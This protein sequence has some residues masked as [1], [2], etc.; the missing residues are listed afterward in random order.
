MEYAAEKEAFRKQTE[1]M[2]LQRKVKRGDAWWPVKV[3]KSYYNSLNQLAVE[4]VRTADNDIEH[5]FEFGRPVMFFAM[6]ETGNS[7]KTGMSGETLEP[8]EAS[9]RLS[10]AS[11]E[12]LEETAETASAT[13]IAEVEAAERISATSTSSAA[14]ALELLCLLP[15]FTIL[16]ILLPFLRITYHIVGLLQSL[17]LCLCLRIVGVKIRVKLLGPL[18]VGLL[19]VLLRYCLIYA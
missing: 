1:E 8:A 9:A 13:E 2:G 4:V 11:E 12:I 10:L 14:K 15:L 7:G 3:T 18:Q 16:V 17:K 5:N 6:K 19:H